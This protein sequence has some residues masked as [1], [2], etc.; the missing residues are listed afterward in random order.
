MWTHF[1][2]QQEPVLRSAAPCHG[3]IT[4]AWGA[5]SEAEE[6]SRQLGTQSIYLISLLQ[7]HQDCLFTCFNLPEASKTFRISTADPEPKLNH[8][9]C[10]VSW[11][12]LSWPSLQGHTAEADRL[13]EAFK[14]SCSVLCIALETQRSKQYLPT[15][16]WKLRQGNSSLNITQ[17]QPVGF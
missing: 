8:S 12:L 9:S 6:Q 10:A 15:S 7:T 14:P 16:V 4:S 1:H 3:S 5:R 11:P 2:L 17:D 13:P